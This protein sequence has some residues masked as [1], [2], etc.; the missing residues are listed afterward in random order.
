MKHDDVLWCLQSS[1]LEEVRFQNLI[2]NG[3]I[4]G[5]LTSFLFNKFINYIDK[6]KIIR[7]LDYICEGEFCSKHFE[8]T[9]YDFL[10]SQYLWHMG[11]TC[12]RLRGNFIPLLRGLFDSLTSNSGI[13]NSWARRYDQYFTKIPKILSKHAFVILTNLRYDYGLLN[14]NEYRKYLKVY[15]LPTHVDYE[16]L[17]APP[18]HHYKGKTIIEILQ[19]EDKNDLESYWEERYKDRP[20]LGIKTESDNAKLFY[21]HWALPIGDRSIYE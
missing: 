3:I 16:E 15:C 7:C 17:V 6:Q 2:D 1:V 4:W 12:R 8:I 5:G 11:D 21:S 18:N 9:M 14:E 19:Q 13:L 20:L 10:T